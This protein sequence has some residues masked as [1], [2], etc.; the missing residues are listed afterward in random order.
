M[1][2]EQRQREVLDDLEAEYQDLDRVLDGL[3]AA[4]WDTPT[5]AEGWIVRDEISHLALSEELAS[6]AARD[7]AAFQERLAAL[8][9]NLDEA[10]REP[11]ERGRAIAPAQLLD[12]WRTERAR[13]LAALREHGPKDRIPWIA[14]EMGT[15]SFATA[16]LMETWAHGQDVIDAV[17]APRP[18]TMR[19]RHVAHI[20]VSTRRFSYHNRGR[21]PPDGEV[22]VELVAP[23]GSI[24]S[25][26]PEDAGDRVT[27][28]AEEFCLVV[29]QR[30]HRD[31]TALVAEGPLAEEWLSIAQAF[32]GPPTDGRK[33]GAVRT[34]G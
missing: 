8:V 1:S 11:L 20:G 14:T 6:L 3:D 25:W 23:D 19:L 32:A 12:W 22:R 10:Q 34:K 17:D 31:D 5:P 13:T 9:A 27:G 26:G 15:I 29:T 2:D 24:W 33:P 16:R 7:P 4:R 21:T 30:R 18:A 28:T